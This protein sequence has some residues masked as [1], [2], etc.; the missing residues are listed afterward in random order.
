MLETLIMPRLRSE[1]LSEVVLLESQCGDLAKQWKK[2]SHSLTRYWLGILQPTLLQHYT[3]TLNL[4]VER[5][6]ANHISENY[7]DF[8]EINWKEIA[9]RNEFAGNTEGSLKKIY[10]RLSNHTRP[11]L[12]VTNSQL[13]PSHVSQYCDEA[14]GEGGKGGRVSAKKAQRQRDVI[15]FFCRRVAQLGIMNFL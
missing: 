13:T 8:S 1:K 15:D 2:H 9:A 12:G 5:I 7:T 3:G 4:R 11:K 14:H 10:F 6:L